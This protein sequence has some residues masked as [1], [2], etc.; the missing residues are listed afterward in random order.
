MMPGIR[1]T[2][3]NENHIPKEA[4]LREKKKSSRQN[5][6]LL[7]AIFIGVA[8]YLDLLFLH[9]LLQ[10]IR[11]ILISPP[12]FQERQNSC[13]LFQVGENGRAQSLLHRSIYSE[14]FLVNSLAFNTA[15]PVPVLGGPGPPGS[16]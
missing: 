10:I 12:E 7:S 16:A 1:W 6:H 13:F 11:R 4:M 3:L 9:Y 5:F 2:R 8:I 14:L 15:G